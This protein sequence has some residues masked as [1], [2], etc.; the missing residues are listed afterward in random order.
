MMNDMGSAGRQHYED[1]LKEAE[2]YRRIKSLGG[3]ED[4]PIAAKIGGVLH[5]V[6]KRLVA[7]G[8]E[9]QNPQTA[10][11]SHTR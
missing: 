7:L 8:E 11:H 5:S 2:A 9:M 3:Q 6:G 1:L 4:F 10:I